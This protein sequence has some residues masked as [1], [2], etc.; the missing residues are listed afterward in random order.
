MYGD[1]RANFDFLQNHLVEAQTGGNIVHV[2]KAG[3]AIALVE[4]I[5]DQ[6]GPWSTSDTVNTAISTS[7]QN[8]TQAV[9]MCL[10]TTAN[11]ATVTYSGTVHGHSYS[12][13]ALSCK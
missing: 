7:A 5:A 1:N 12:P 2:E 8:L 4:L 6:F 9:A 11:P 13:A 3:E 10:N